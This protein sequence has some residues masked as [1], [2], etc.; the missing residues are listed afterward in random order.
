MQ[1]VY[2]SW[3][4]PL[5][6][7]EILHL[8]PMCLCRTS[9]AP[10][11][12]YATVYGL[13]H[14]HR[15][16]CYNVRSHT[17]PSLHMLQYTV[18]YTT[19]ATYATI[20]GVI[21]NHRYICYNIRCHTQPSLHMLQYTVSY[22]TIAAYATTYGLIHN[23]RCIHYNTQSQKQPSLHTLQYTGPQNKFVFTVI[24]SAYTTKYTPY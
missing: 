6:C 3:N 11:A 2:Q 24:T 15:Y 18:S 16:I 4:V 1:T 21:H 23:H 20:Y 7:A 19:I 13:I 10:I 9:E 12:A 22:T 8:A 17:Q 5:T 14:N